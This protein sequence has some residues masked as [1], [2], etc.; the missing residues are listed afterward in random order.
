[1]AKETNKNNTTIIYATYPSKAMVIEAINQNSGDHK[2]HQMQVFD[3]M[4]GNAMRN[5]FVMLCINGKLSNHKTN[6]NKGVQQQTIK[7]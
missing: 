1:M 3:N 2:K 4:R 6:Q 7:V 5:Y